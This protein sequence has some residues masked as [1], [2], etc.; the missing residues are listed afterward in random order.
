MTT[1]KIS[2]NK[3]KEFIE[4]CNKVS[5]ASE[6]KNISTYLSTSEYIKFEIL[7]GDCFLIKNVISSFVEFK[8]DVSSFF[9]DDIEFLIHEK[10]LKD[11]CG[12]ISSEYLY[13]QIDESINTT[14]G[15]VTKLVKISDTE[16][17]KDSKKLNYINSLIDIKLFPETKYRTS[18]Y[19]NGK[20]KINEEVLNSIEIASVHVIRDN[21]KP[22]LS[23]IY[24]GAYE[25]DKHL[26]EGC[27]IFS[28]DSQC[29]YSKK[30]NQKFPPIAIQFVETKILLGLKSCD[31]FVTE[32]HN[33][34]FVGS[35][36][37]FGY[38][39]IDN[40]N[41]FDYNGFKNY[42]TKQNSITIK[43]EDILLFCLR[44]RNSSNSSK[45]SFLNSTCLFDKQENIVRFIYNN[46][47]TNDEDIKECQII[48]NVV[49]EFEK[50]ILNHNQ[51]YDILKTLSYNTITISIEQYYIGLTTKE[52]ENYF[53]FLPIITL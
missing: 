39:H 29:F 30:F 2:L 21:V 26:I 44:A 6:G 40:T 20:T 9:Y 38:R 22:N 8:I 5:G 35:N 13:I 19:K 48:G 34:Y 36:V 25:K 46:D 41:G 32:G 1:L 50:F 12:T 42:L 37:V 16:K 33:V 17:F 45:D 47:K 28:A 53:G 11:F 4:F 23:C 52:D 10:K 31:Y 27:D 51:L 18:N 14:N 49:G 7:M 24:L 15:D 43:V 3:I